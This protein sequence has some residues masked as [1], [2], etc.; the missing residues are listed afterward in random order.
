M[1][2]RLAPRHLLIVAAVALCG[3]LLVGLI[4]YAATGLARFREA[5]ARRSTVVYAA[6][7]VLG[8]GTHVGRIDLAGTLSRLAYQETSG[9]PTTPGQFRRL[10][11]AWEIVPR[12]GQAG[13]ARRGRPVQLDI[14]GERIARLSD[15]GAPIDSLALEP[16][17]LTGAGAVPGEAYRFVQLAEVPTSL[18]LA[19][20]SA[21]D[22]RFFD[23]PGLDARAV[24]RAF[25]SNVRAGRVVE[26]GSTITQQLVKN[27]LLS[28]ERTV[29]RKLQE[30]WLSAALE[31]RYSKEQILEAYLNDLYLGHLGGAAIRGVGAGSRAYFRKEVHELTLGQAALIAGM[32]RGP[33]N[34]SP[35]ASVDRARARRDVVLG[36]M[37]EL[38]KIT[39]TEYERARR[40][41]VRAPSGTPAG[42]VA[43][44]LIDYVRQGLDGVAELERAGQHPAQI[45]TTLDLPLQR[46]A[47]AAVAAGLDR[48]ETR[49]P[50]LRR[51]EAEERV[52]AALIVL[53]P[54]TGRIRALVGGRSYAA[55]QY[56]RAALARRQPG[57][58][59]K[60]FVFLAALTNA[61]G[62]P[63]LTA[64]SMVDDTPI[65]IANGQSAWSPRNYEDRYEG[66]VT[67]RRALEKS[68]NAA[69]IR[70]AQTV[71]WSTIIQR[72]QALGIQS[73]LK[74]V[75]ALA[76]G[77]FEVTP[78]ELARA[79]LVMSNGGLLFET[80]AVDRV[81]DRKG[82]PWAVTDPNGVRVL[83]PAEAYLM[84]SLLEG[85]VNS[86]TGTPVR[87]AGLTGSL[88][89]KTGTTNDGRDAWF[90]GYSS[91]L[92][93]LVWVGFDGG[94][95]HGLSG[96]Q[97]ALPIWGDFMK[98]A[99]DAYPGTPFTVPAGV[100]IV[101]ID[102]STG[103]RATSYCPTVAPETFLAGTEPE[104]CD[105]HGGFGREIF[106]GWDRVR[107]WFS[108][109]AR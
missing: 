64:A 83:A 17:I 73:E 98:R 36:R 32:I 68:L 3:L 34:Y 47:E 93:A 104:A 2:L 86:G 82:Q 56:N 61:D 22:D 24:A 49:W 105:E 62:R 29:F 19:V 9:R 26:G 92:L 90:V 69:T 37:L 52:Q 35:V 67:V 38:G 25:W 76:L 102:T 33:N 43:P 77:A 53:E 97:A 106:R 70:V 13:Q 95:A 50:R 89:G 60:P 31:W 12:D 54:Q 10:R 100:S 65:T 87:V 72:A 80:T 59:F 74:P 81:V 1:R 16:E 40:E 75:P 8:P 30:A 84:T 48:L 18:R 20:L 58:A 44:Y 4:T 28:A 23:H 63:A 11:D 41:P 21:E 101:N 14:Q 78:L 6:P 7:Q 5:D 99:T 51:K 107:D 57:S 39:E 108:R 79:Y 66:R 55:S 42:P 88:A 71:G 91:N 109:W 94:D 45:F 103:K 96:A 46:F 27:R 15:N 85:A